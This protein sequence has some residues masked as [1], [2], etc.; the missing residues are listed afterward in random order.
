MSYVITGDVVVMRELGT[1]G[2]VVGNLEFH[3]KCLRNGITRKIKELRLLSY[4]APDIEVT[5][6]HYGEV[7]RLVIF[8]SL[9]LATIFY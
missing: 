4:V 6:R 1:T 5:L 3:I 8:T 2:D 9:V 7:Y